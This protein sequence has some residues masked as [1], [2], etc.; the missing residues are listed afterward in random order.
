[1]TAMN[2]AP[3]GWQPFGPDLHRYVVKEK[4][5]PQLIGLHGAHGAGKAT[6]AAYLCDAHDFRSYALADPLRR[7]LYA[8]DP[9]LSS[10][11][12]LRTLIDSGGWTDALTHRIHG[13]EVSRLLRTMRLDVARDVFGP[14]VWLRRLE[15]ATVADAELLGVAPAVITDVL[16]AD[17]AQWVLDNGGVVWQVDRPGHVPT[18]QIHDRLISA[19]INNDATELAL[20]R[21]VDRAIAGISRINDAVLA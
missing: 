15:A 21:R 4:A 3:S 18:V 6:V 13:P 7:A 20:T 16:T 10:R 11:E 9:L 14:D 5:F 19:V 17:E 1:M 12:S 2:P 8:L